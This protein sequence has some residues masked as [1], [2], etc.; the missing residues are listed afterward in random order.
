VIEKSNVY[1]PV[2]Y[3]H[4]L[5]ILKQEGYRFAAF[6]EIFSQD[7]AQKVVY[8]RH[9]IDYSI[10]W[11]LAFARINADA[12]IGATFFFQ[13]RS[14]IYNLLAYPTLSVLKE[15][16]GLGQSLAL[17]F[18]IDDSVPANDQD[19]VA[20]IILDFQ[21]AKQFVPK[22][23]PVF[24]WH[25]PSLAP[26]LV[27]RGLDL[28]VP[29]MTNAYSRYFQETVKYYSD[30]NLRHSVDDLEKIILKEEPQLQLLLHPFQWMAQGRNMQEVLA[31]TWVQVIR[32]REREF[33]TNH[34]YRGLFPFGMPDQWLGHLSTCL[35]SYRAPLKSS[36][37]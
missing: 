18:T 29:G 27:Q 1:A 2:A 32:E 13:S 25:N 36:A 30:S 12:G 35:A 6:R 31:N 37:R 11:A 16:A 4:L 19:L 8:L 33:L 5:E 28:V 24:S 26:E 20:Q 21:A 3:R 10:D 15:I 22:L 17:H 14:P 23:Q 34:I 9:D 7:D